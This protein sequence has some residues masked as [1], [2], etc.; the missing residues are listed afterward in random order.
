MTRAII[1]QTGF[2]GCES[3]CVCV[4]IMAESSLQIASMQPRAVSSRAKCEDWASSKIVLF[5]TGR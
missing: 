5:V 2:D 4:C 3:V 1:K